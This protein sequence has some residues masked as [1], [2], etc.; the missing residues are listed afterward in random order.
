VSKNVEY[1]VHGTIVPRDN[2]FLTGNNTSLP[3]KTDYTMKSK[4]DYNIEF[5]SYIYL[6]KKRNRSSDSGL[7]FPHGLSLFRSSYTSMLSMG[8]HSLNHM[9]LT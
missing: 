1:R 3:E 6:P 8:I 5:S 4:N 9:T 7:N 2:N